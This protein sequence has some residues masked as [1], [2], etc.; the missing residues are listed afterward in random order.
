M[1]RF[2]PGLKVSMTGHGCFGRPA[3][4]DKAFY[5]KYPALLSAAFLIDCHTLVTIISYRYAFP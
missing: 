3:G 4:L 5:G 2:S 1:P